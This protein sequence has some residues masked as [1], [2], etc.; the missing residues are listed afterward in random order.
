MIRS[1]SF[2]AA[3]FMSGISYSFFSK[4]TTKDTCKDNNVFPFDTMLTPTGAKRMF[5]RVQNGELLIDKDKDKL[6]KYF[7]YKCRESNEKSS[8]HFRREREKTGR[9][10]GLLELAWMDIYSTRC[11]GEEIIE[12]EDK[13]ICWKC[14]RK[15]IPAYFLEAFD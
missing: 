9:G 1:A 4:D 12:K 11:F 5:E 3:G 7:R 10:G 8:D 13:Y 2:F 15:H 14:G 6:N